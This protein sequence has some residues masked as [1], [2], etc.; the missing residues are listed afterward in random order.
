[1]LPHN[2]LLGIAGYM[3]C[4]KSTF[5]AL[6]SRYGLRIVDADIEAKSLMTADGEIHRQLIDAFGKT[7]KTN[8]GIN[9]SELGRFAFDSEQTVKTLNNIVH[10]K[11][12]KRLHDLVFSN[13]GPC[14]LDAALIPLWGIEDWFD[15]CLWVFADQLIR[16]KRIKDKA[17]LAPEQIVLRMKIQESIV[18]IPQGPKWSFLSNDRSL[19]ILRSAVTL[20]I[21][22]EEEKRQ[23]L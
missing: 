16:E 7:I 9:F 8:T 12:V 1:M 4:G 10:P 11:L 23:H 13:N 2:F 19:D 22:T 21:K 20:F 5:A 18:P 6:L 14:I 15:S 3:G 17:I